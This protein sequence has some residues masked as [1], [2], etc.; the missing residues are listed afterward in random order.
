M[1]LRTFFTLCDS[2]L[3][4]E[5]TLKTLK[6]QSEQANRDFAQA[7]A[8]LNDLAK[9][10]E[11]KTSEIR[12]EAKKSVTAYANKKNYDSLREYLTI[13]MSSFDSSMQPMLQSLLSNDVPAIDRASVLATLYPELFARYL[14]TDLNEKAEIVTLIE[15]KD[16]LV[17]EKNDKE[18]QRNDLSSSL[19]EINKRIKNEEGRF[20]FPLKHVV[21]IVSMSELEAWEKVLPRIKDLKKKAME[22]DKAASA[23]SEMISSPEDLMLTDIA[24]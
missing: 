6:N 10:L 23:E 11:K 21:E 24:D 1:D 19:T 20:D 13:N 9:L 17:S 16:K 3:I 2:L 8:R 22:A 12:E 15:E 14:G 18:K 5:N 4:S 7:E